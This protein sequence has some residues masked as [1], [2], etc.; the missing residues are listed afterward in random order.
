MAQGNLATKIAS[1]E[2]QIKV[3]KGQ[4]KKKKKERA[5]AQMDGLL[6]GKSDTSFDEIRAVEI[7]TPEELK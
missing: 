1:L 3:L 6:K 5:L 4:A 7:S 2:L